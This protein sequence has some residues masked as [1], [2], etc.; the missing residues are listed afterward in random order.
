MKSAIET[1][2]QIDVKWLCALW[3]R[4]EYSSMAELLYG[5]IQIANKLD[6]KASEE[7]SFLI[8]ICREGRDCDRTAS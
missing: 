2:G 4:E 3:D 8:K 7:C 1:C 5:F 6:P